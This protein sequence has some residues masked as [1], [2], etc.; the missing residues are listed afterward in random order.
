MRRWS[1]VRGYVAES[2]IGTSRHTDIF[3]GGQRP[4]VADLLLDNKSDEISTWYAGK[5]NESKLKEGIYQVTDFFP[6]MGETGKWIRFTSTLIKD[7]KG[8]TI[9]SMVAFED[10]TELKQASEYLQEQWYFLQ[11]IIDSIPLPLYYKGS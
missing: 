10:L 6:L 11:E 3:Y 8:A 2:I 7:S 9:G 5:Y 1:S 4:M